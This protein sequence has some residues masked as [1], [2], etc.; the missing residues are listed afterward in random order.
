ME[1]IDQALWRD[2][3]HNPVHEIQKDLQKI[4]RYFE[5][6]LGPEAG[7][8]DKNIIAERQLRIVEVEVKNLI[9]A[10]GQLKRD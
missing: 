8:Y 4:R 10:I 7:L 3:V 5:H 9:S 6:L 2:N 1:N